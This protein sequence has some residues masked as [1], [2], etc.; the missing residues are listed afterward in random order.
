MTQDTVRS[1]ILLLLFPLCSCFLWFVTYSMV[2]L[3]LTM[4][5]CGG[6]GTIST[7]LFYSYQHPFSLELLQAVNHVIIRH[8]VI[9]FSYCFL[10]FFNSRFFVSA[11]YLA[12]AGWLGH[13]EIVKLLFLPFIGLDLETIYH[14]VPLEYYAIRYKQLDNIAEYLHSSWPHHMLL[15]LL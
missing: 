5:I 3:W 13:L 1:F 11:L 9:L 14:R 7:L 2:T 8:C 4:G 12:A 15:I 6:I 10:F